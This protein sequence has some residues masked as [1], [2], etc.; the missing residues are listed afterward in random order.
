MS[1]APQSPKFTEAEYLALE[2]AGETR[3]EYSQGN[4][5]AVAGAKRNHNL[6]CTNIVGN[7][8][9]ALKANGCEIYQSDMRVRVKEA[10]AYRYPDVVIV[11]GDPVFTDENEDTLLNPTVLIEVL[12]PSTAADDR[13]VKSW[14]YR[15]LAS[16][17]DYLLIWPDDVR[18]EHYQRQGAGWMLLEVVGLDAS[19]RLESA[20]ITLDFARVY[21]GIDLEAE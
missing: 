13:G 12:S 11:C 5:Y 8:R 14:E 16:L 18:A 1:T 3:H 17:Q 7:Y 2:R 21:D 15:Q 6:I 10:R 9:H 19:I 20:G 4:I